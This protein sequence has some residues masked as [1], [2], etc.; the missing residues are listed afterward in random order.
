MNTPRALFTLLTLST[1]FCAV[2]R[3]AE[4][5][6]VVAASTSTTVETQSSVPPKQDA[7]LDHGVKELG[8]SAKRAD[9][10]AR[11]WDIAPKFLHAVLASDARAAL[12]VELEK[13]EAKSIVRIRARWSGA[14]QRS[15]VQ[16]EIEERLRSMAHKIAQLCGV[17]RP[18]VT[19]TTTPAGAVKGDPCTPPPPP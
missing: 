4:P 5:A 10:L 13:L 2:L 19:C 6:A 15:D 7:C 17:P 9:P 18:D 12:T 14:P 3:A 1:L 11:R 16:L 8:M